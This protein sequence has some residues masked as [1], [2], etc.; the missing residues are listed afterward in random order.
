MAASAGMAVVASSLSCGVEAYRVHKR[1]LRGEQGGVIEHGRESGPQGQLDTH[2]PARGSPEDPSVPSHSNTATRPP[3]G[4][5]PSPPARHV[6]AAPMTAG[7]MWALNMLTG[8]SPEVGG[9]HMWSWGR[10]SK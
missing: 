5:L 8:A 3:E 2:Y 7:D 6:T 4:H 9:G 10:H 1:E